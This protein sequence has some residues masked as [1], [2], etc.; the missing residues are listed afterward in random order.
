MNANSP[1]YYRPQ[2]ATQ[3][4]QA[5]SAAPQ[6]PYHPHDHHATT[7]QFTWTNG[8]LGVAEAS[9]LQLAPGRWPQRIH[10][11]SHKTGDTR[12]FFLTGTITGGGRSYHKDG[13]NLHIL[14][15]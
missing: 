14:N 9:T 8:N 2:R 4:K 7:R 1:F 12:T 11:R 13:I 6:N 15:D 5:I 10:V 3:A